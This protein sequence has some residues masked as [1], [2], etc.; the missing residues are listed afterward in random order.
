MAGEHAAAI[1]QTSD[2]SIGHEAR[3]LPDLRDKVDAVVPAIVT[4]FGDADLQFERRVHTALPMDHKADVAILF[5]DDNF[6]YSRSK[7]SLLH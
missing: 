5:A 7:N 1:E 4:C 2:L 6:V 3:Q